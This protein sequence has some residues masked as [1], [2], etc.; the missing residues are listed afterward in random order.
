MQSIFSFYSIYSKIDLILATRKNIVF[1]HQ[2]IR[3]S[4]YFLF[5]NS[6]ISLVLIVVH[7]STITVIA[8]RLQSMSDMPK[9]TFKMPAQITLL[10]F[11]NT[12]TNIH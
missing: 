9:L 3:I 7:L 10:G 6:T 5:N 8:L 1:Y 2:F 11:S 4:S 12:H